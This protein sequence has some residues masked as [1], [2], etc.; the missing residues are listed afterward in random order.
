M[1]FTDQ[2]PSLKIFPHE[3]QGKSTSFYK[4]I[5]HSIKKS[6]GAMRLAPSSN[7]PTGSPTPGSPLTVTPNTKTTTHSS[8][9]TS[10]LPT[11]AETQSPE[12]IPTLPTSSNSSTLPLQPSS[13]NTPT[14]L[15][16][17]QSYSPSLRNTT[18]LNN[19]PAFTR[20]RPSTTTNHQLHLAQL[21]GT[22]F[23]GHQK[24]PTNIAT[25]T[26]STHD[27]IRF[28]ISGQSFPV[29][30]YQPLPQT[31]EDIQR[32]MLETQDPITHAPSTLKTHKY[33]SLDLI[34]LPKPP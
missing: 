13:S 27:P 21:N 6:K 26:F 14:S 33:P 18:P 16:T 1:T 32:Y 29:Q 23:S 10:A 2:E 9:P 19:T 5:S 34:P 15:I 12:D 3:P 28:Y 20:S 8:M 4:Y 24:K 25:I 11:Q 30:P 22:D 17:L 31:M 7:S